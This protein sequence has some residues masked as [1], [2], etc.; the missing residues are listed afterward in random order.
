M[1]SQRTI[2]KLRDIINAAK[3]CAQVINGE[4]AKKTEANPLTE[5][6]KNTIKRNVAHLEIVMADGE[7]TNSGEDVS[8]LASA[9]LSGKAALE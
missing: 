4:I 3:D 9:I 8:E 5:D 7:I 2:E 1:S 6:S